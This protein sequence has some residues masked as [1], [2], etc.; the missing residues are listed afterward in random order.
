MISPCWYRFAW[1]TTL[2]RGSVLPQT[3][4]LFE[5]SY[6]GCDQ[7]SIE[8]SHQS[9]RPPTTL[10]QAYARTR[11][12][13][14]GKPYRPIWMFAAPE[15]DRTNVFDALVPVMGRRD[16]SQRCTVLDSERR[17]IQAIGEQDIG[18]E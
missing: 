17:S 10:L 15:L 5:A 11:M 9:S 8:P 16:Q 1:S 6:G 2:A 18:S 4:C 3:Q 12:R 14:E 13:H 7:W